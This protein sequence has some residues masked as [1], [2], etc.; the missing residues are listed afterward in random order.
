MTEICSEVEL[1]PV[2]VVL[3]FDGLPKTKIFCSFG[4]PQYS[5][6]GLPMS[7]GSCLQ[8]LTHFLHYEIVMVWLVLI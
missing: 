2:A 3:G 7:R 1:A 8:I 4:L 5:F 6:D